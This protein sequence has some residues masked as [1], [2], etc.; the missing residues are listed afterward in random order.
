[1]PER[2]VRYYPG[3]EQK[4]PDEDRL[5]QEIVEQMAET[6]CKVFDKHRHAVRDA[7]AKS[8]GF[9]KGILKVPE[10]LPEHLRQGLFAHPGHYDVMV[11]L[12]AAPGD[13]RSDKI[14]APHGFA[15]KILNVPGHRLLPD[16]PSDGHNQDFLMVN[17]P[18][19]AFGT[20][21]KYKQMLPFITQGEQAPESMMRGMRSVLRGVNQLVESAGVPAPA[22]LQG[23][24]RSQ[25]HILGETYH[26]MA[27]LRYGDYITKISVAP[28]SDSV[29]TLTGQQ[30]QI[31]SESTIRDLVRD[32]FKHNT[33]DYVI[34]A[35]L[36]TDL[37]RMPVEDAAVLWREEES[38][39]QNIGI[40]H[41]PQQDTFGPARRVYSD[42][43]LSF[44]PWHGIREHQPLGSIMRVRIQAYEHSSSF[45]HRMN[46][47]P[48]AE[49][50]NIDEMPD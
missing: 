28:E 19:L 35:Q 50:R 42:D 4:Q 30:M 9:L 27:A 29:K 22:T 11:R 26:T 36:C 34:R 49:P 3:V 32:F 43:V 16:D 47:Q 25:N 2:Y 44:N 37:E 23:L 31:E 45:R 6:N 8:H 7:H 40:L 48:R 10:H 20:V 39:H 15:L 14:P 17:I 38:P 24:A 13:L 12:S 41:F 1:M 5:I 33:A 21:R 18:V 46:V